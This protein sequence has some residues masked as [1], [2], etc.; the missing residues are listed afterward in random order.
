MWAGCFFVT[1]FF[2]HVRGEGELL[3]IFVT[4]EGELKSYIRTTFPS[5]V[6]YFVLPCCVFIEV[7]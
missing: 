3:Y 2:T 7:Y 5:H 6:A 4:V 1:L